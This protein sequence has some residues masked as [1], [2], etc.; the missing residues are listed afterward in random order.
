MTCSDPRVLG[1]KSC[2]V[3]D[4]FQSW[5][6]I[7]NVIQQKGDTCICA[8][9]PAAIVPFMGLREKAPTCKLLTVSPF[10]F[11]GL[12]LSSLLFGRDDGSS[13]ARLNSLYWKGNTPVFANSM[14]RG[15]DWEL[16]VVGWKL[17]PFAGVTQ[18]LLNTAEMATCIQIMQDA[19]KNRI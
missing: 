13:G 9:A 1:C 3:P 18:N 15:A 14:Q 6:C 2:A 16:Y 17:M 11:P 5:I 7:W 19:T 12:D 4:S 10:P 8:E